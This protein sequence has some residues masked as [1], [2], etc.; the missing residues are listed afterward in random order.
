MLCPSVLGDPPSSSRTDP[1]FRTTRAAAAA[2]EEEEEEE[3]AEDPS[4]RAEEEPSRAVPFH[5]Q[6]E[7]QPNQQFVTA[8]HGGDKGHRTRPRRPAG[9]PHHSRGNQP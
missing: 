3:E 8:N 5:T 4:C 6:W 7:R 2:G 1:T 9:P